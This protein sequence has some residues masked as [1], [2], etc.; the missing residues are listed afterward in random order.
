[1]GKRE[2]NQCSPVKDCGGRV[3]APELHYL[4][5]KSDD[6]PGSG[7][8]FISFHFHCAGGGSGLL[9]SSTGGP[10]G[11]YTDLVHG[12]PGG[13]VS[14]FQDPADGEV[15]TI[16]SGSALIASRLSRNMSAIVERIVLSP[17]CESPCQHS[18][19]GFE[20]P[21]VVEANGTYFLSSSAFG[22]A[23]AH[24]GPSSMFNGPSAP[25][26]SHYS[27]YMGSARAFR[28]PYTDGRLTEPG[29]W[30]AVDNGGH[31][32]YFAVNGTLYGTVW[33]GSEPNG[34]VPPAYKALINLPSVTR[35]ELV[36]GRLVQAARA[37]GA[38]PTATAMEKPPFK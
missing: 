27:A 19:I 25:A 33:Y 26:D 4:P 13:D 22:N 15:Y 17:E 37:G 2:G 14:L 11:P 3:W 30:L 23:S 35:M 7:G 10:F 8:W 32:N 29:S 18:A 36:N 5:S 6:V 34:D 31:N 1:M 20:G 38:Q 24:G 9:R 28:G 16:S 12:V 21:F